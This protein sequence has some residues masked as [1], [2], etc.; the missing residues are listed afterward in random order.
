[1]KACESCS[2]SRVDIGKNHQKQPVIIRAIGMVFVYLPIITFPFVVLTT[3][4]V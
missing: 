3:I 2:A 4:C 1:M